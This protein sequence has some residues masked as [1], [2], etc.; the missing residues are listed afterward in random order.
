MLQLMH[1]RWQQQI[2]CLQCNVVAPEPG[3]PLY[4]YVNLHNRI[5][6]AHNV[7][8]QRTLMLWDFVGF[9]PQNV[10]PNDFQFLCFEIDNYLQYMH[11]LVG[12]KSKVN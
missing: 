4:S 6:N 7:F 10:Q 9:Y 5:V 1:N 12:K 8:H 2:N 11:Y 3:D